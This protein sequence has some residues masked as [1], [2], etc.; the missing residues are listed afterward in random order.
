M[1]AVEVEDNTGSESGDFSWSYKGLLNCS[2]ASMDNMPTPVDDNCPHSLDI[3]SSPS[4]ER[5]G[6]HRASADK[7]TNAAESEEDTTHMEEEAPDTS[8]KKQADGKQKKGTAIRDH[9][10]AAVAEIASE[11]A[12]ESGEKK[13]KDVFG[14]T[15]KS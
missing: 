9:V 15:P 14:T 11:R 13:R 10:D 12:S 7:D 5:S 1:Q 4:P 6:S 3:Q 8:I 2:I